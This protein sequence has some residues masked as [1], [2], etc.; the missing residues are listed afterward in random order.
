MSGR[1]PQPVVGV[2]CLRADAVLLIRRSKPPR[3]G[4]WSVP[5]GRVEWGETL[6]QAALR[7]LTEEAGVTATLLDLV[8]VYDGVFPA[9]DRHYVLIDYAARW[10]AGEPVGGDDA[11]EA[12][13]WPVAEAIEAVGWAPTKDLIRAAW[14]RFGAL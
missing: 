7:E 9:D 10:V 1:Y 14:E 6:A 3:E 12:R 4:E 11:L 13:F 2:V 5:G 8:G